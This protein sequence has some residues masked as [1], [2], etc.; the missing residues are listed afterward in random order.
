MRKPGPCGTPKPISQ[1]HRKTT[2][3]PCSP[4]YRHPDSYKML[5]AV[6]QPLLV[7]SQVP[8]PELLWASHLDLLESLLVASSGPALAA[9]QVNQPGRRLLNLQRLV[10]QRSNIQYQGLGGFCGML[11]Y[12]VPYRRQDM[13]LEL[14]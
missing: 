1:G 5:Y 6:F 4:I 14:P 3:K 2:E 7:Q 9:R 8:L 10:F 11:G 13:A 12:R